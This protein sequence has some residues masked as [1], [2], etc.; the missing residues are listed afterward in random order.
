MGRVERVNYRQSFFC[1]DFG[2]VFG[3][4]STLAAVLNLVRIRR[5]IATELLQSKL[6]NP[7]AE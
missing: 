6:T 3:K 1:D 7:F 4:A 2:Q 5:F